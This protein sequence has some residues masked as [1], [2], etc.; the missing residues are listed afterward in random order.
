MSKALNGPITA[1]SKDLE[2]M[3]PITLPITEHSLNSTDEKIDAL[4][5]LQRVN[6]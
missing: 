1:F 5:N 2:N 6:E 4:Y 3:I